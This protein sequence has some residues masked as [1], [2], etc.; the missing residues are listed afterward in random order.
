MSVDAQGDSR[1]GVAEPGSHYVDWNFREQQGGGVQV[2]E[3]KG[4]RYINT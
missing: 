1:V 4:R 3:A 2:A